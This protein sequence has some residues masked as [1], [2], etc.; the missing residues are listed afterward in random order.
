MNEWE[1]KVE[2]ILLIAET[3]NAIPLRQLSAD[4]IK[5]AEE[6]EWEQA[7]HETNN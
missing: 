1:K 2:A 3:L 7:R 6:Q 5:M 4:L